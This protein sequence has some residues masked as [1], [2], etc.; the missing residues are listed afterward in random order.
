[1]HIE[2]RRGDIT[3]LPDVDAIVNAAN[4][5]LWLGSG[6]AG[7]IAR[8]GGPSIEAEAVPQGPIA[9]GDAVI[10]KA[11][12]LPNRF[13]IH[14]AAMG[15]RPQDDLTP[16]HPGSLSSG[17]II[18]RAVLAS[19]DLAQRHGCRSIAFPALATGVGA[20]P[21]DVCAEAMLA[22]ANDWASSHPNA[23]LSH[24]VFVVFSAEDH[25]AFQ[26]VALARQAD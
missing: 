4:T 11:G 14:A 6:V 20:L 26:R 9:L 19:L 7:A 16:K 3:R 13:V 8:A 17:P 23:T 2:L 15:Y 1:M 10:T 12:T 21:V 22:A 18:R 24:V 25:V 5:E